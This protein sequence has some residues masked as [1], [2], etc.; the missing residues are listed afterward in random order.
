LIVA[1][2]AVPQPAAIVVL[3][4]AGTYL[5]RTRAA[6]Q[7]FTAGRAPKI[8]LTNDNERGRWVSAEQ[9]NPFFSERAAA[10]LLNAGVPANKIELIP[11]PIF[12]TYE[13]AHAVRAYAVAHEL[14]SLLIVTS[15]YHSRRAWWTWAR[16][17]RGSGIELGMTHAP[18]GEQTPAPAVWWM[19]W[20]GWRAVAV[21]YPKLI[22]YWLRYA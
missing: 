18:T 4:G 7:L 9:R 2:D 21:E 6:A 12:S 14:R 8:I 1:A 13:E 10:E 3:S 11:Q 5:E 17:F 16:V 19:Q 22:Y 15:A 20:H